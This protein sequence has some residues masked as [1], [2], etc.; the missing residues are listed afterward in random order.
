MKV[1]LDMITD[2]ITDLNC[3]VARWAA[4]HHVDTFFFH[5]VVMEINKVITE[6]YHKQ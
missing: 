2:L 1:T 5:K 3:T 4:R 6:L